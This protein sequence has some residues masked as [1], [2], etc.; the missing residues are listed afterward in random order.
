MKKRKDECLVCGVRNCNH[1]VFS[2]H[3]YGCVFVYDEIACQSHS[4]ELY[5]NADSYQGLKCYFE[6]TGI[7]KRGDKFDV[8]GV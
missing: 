1:R 3:S 5:K 2:V 6:T 4:A 7:V 8:K